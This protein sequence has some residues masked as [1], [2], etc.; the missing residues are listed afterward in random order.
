MMAEQKSETRYFKGD[1]QVDM[2]VEITQVHLIF[3]MNESE[4]QDS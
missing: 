2:R 1:R 4:R 3:M